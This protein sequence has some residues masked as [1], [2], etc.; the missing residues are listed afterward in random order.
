MKRKAVESAI[1]QA[2]FE[3]SGDIRAIYREMD[4]KHGHKPKWLEPG[5][6]DKPLAR[7]YA[8]ALA[9][10]VLELLEAIDV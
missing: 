9:P 5:S 1:A 8:K 6:Y 2:L 10:R 7:Q 4:E 3:K